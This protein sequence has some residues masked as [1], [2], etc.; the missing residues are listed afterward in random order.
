MTLTA[1]IGTRKT[2]NNL[3][4]VHITINEYLPFQNENG[5]YLHPRARFELSSSPRGK[6]FTTRSAANYWACKW[7][8]A[9]NSHAELEKILVWKAKKDATLKAA[10]DNCARERELF[11]SAEKKD[12]DLQAAEQ[13]LK[14]DECLEDYENE[15]LFETAGRE[16]EE[17]HGAPLAEVMS[18][19]DKYEV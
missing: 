18:N 3:F 2:A 17:L 11:E 4:R 7:R 6:V 15:E 16:A 1:H 5:S 12:T 10:H 13:W 9:L 19:P 14:S 8:V